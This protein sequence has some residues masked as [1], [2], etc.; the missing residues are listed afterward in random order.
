MVTKQTRMRTCGL[1]ALC[2]LMG[3]G[4]CAQEPSPDDLQ[5]LREACGDGA[6]VHHAAGRL[7]LTELSTGLSTFM[8]FGNQPEFSPDGTRVAWIDGTSAKGRLRRDD[9]RIHVIAENIEPA[10]GVHWFDD[11][12][13]LLVL[14]R[15]RDRG[16]YRVSLTGDITPVPELTKLG[17]GGYECDVRLAPDGV[18]SYVA[19]RSWRTSDGRRGVLPGTCSVSLSLDGRS[20][21]SLH[22]PHKRCSITA[23]RTGG[24]ELELRWPYRGGFDNHRW[25]SNDPRFIVAVDEHHQ[26]MAVMTYD[27]SRCTRLGTLGHAEHMMYGDFTVGTGEGDPWPDEAEETGP[28]APWPVTVEGL[29]FR[30]TSGRHS[31][32][33]VDAGGVRRL[34][35]LEAGGMARLGRHFDMKLTRRGG[36]FVSEPAAGAR[37]TRACAGARALTVEALVTPSRDTA[38]DGRILGQ[39]G[40]DGRLNFL[41]E[42]DDN[43]LRFTLGGG[44]AGRPDAGTLTMPARHLDGPTHVV[45]VVGAHLVTGYL[46]GRRVA[47]VS[48]EAP[49]LDRWENLPLSFGAPEDHARH[50]AGALERIALYA[51][52]LSAEEVARK[53]EAIRRD[54]GE[55]IDPERHLVRG[56]LT[57]VVPIPNVELY[58]NALV[59]FEY[60]LADRP[61]ALSPS[62]MVVHWGVLNGRPDERVRDR[63]IG[64]TFDLRLEPL[65]DHEQLNAIKLVIE[66]QDYARELFL[67]VSE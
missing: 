53:A 52:A 33:M 26:T 10:A 54:L 40:A 59:A 21:T 62:V 12:E 9:D 14:N 45:V 66:E 32:T 11:D 8:A 28:L 67:D 34:C 50:W 43:A 13:V 63:A 46:N 7:Y 58:P 24:H 22:N 25:A 56:T 19:K 16:W 65:A 36:T 30:W 60:E 17:L 44:P 48:V 47:E 31:N 20:A 29:A 49:G 2:G 3:A 42:Q 35:R 1:L 41:L 6:L 55:R 39:V 61:A 51:R 23:I 15:S 4:A 64:S 27:G 18:W 37:I 38:S 57:R 5:W